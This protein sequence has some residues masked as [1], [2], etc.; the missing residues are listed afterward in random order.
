VS[1]VDAARKTPRRRPPSTETDSFGA[2]SCRMLAVCANH[3]PVVNEKGRRVRCETG[4][5]RRRRNARIAAAPPPSLSGFRRNVD[6]R[7]AGIL[8]RETHRTHRDLESKASNRADTTWRGEYTRAWSYRNPPLLENLESVLTSDGPPR[9]PTTAAPPPPPPPRPPARRLT[10]PVPTD[11]LEANHTRRAAGRDDPR[12]AP[13][14]RSRE[15]ARPSSTV[16]YERR[17][18]AR[19]LR[20]P[21]PW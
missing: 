8:E 1:T 11:L 5:G 21:S 3:Q 15:S 16:P 18:G 19:S 20:G 2:A 14:P 4:V 13:R 6:V 12:D 17:D 7:G 10:S 9:S